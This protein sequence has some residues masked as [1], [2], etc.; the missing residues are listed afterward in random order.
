MTETKPG[1]IFVAIPAI[2]AEIGPIGKDRKNLQQGFM[3]RG[4]DD[5]YNTVNPL[6]AKHG[7]F[8]TSE[9]LE[10]IREE[11]RSAA[12]KALLYTILKV[13]FTFYAMDGSNVSSVVMGEGMDSGDKSCNK[14]MSVAFKYA[15]F[16]LLCIPTEAV[17]PD[18]E[19]H[20]VKS[21]E[22]EP[23][24]PAAATTPPTDRVVSLDVLR[25]TGIISG[26]QEFTGGTDD[27]PWRK[28]VVKVDEREFFTF[29]EEMADRLTEYSK[30]EEEVELVFR[31]EVYK[32][33]AQNK[34]VGMKKTIV[35]EG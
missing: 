30:R 1:Q 26:L 33:K 2:L 14:A 11:R 29:D 25:A 4:V 31:S 6:L 5:V 8:V 9:V 20:E 16:Q 23:R 34:I 7:V 15:L 28:I 10:C 12:D 21:K 32:G 17:D 22:A 13:R 3:Y 19:S 18:A 24:K 35:A 27:K